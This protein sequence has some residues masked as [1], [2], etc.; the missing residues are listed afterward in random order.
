M[1]GQRLRKK[2]Q[3]NQTLLI[4]GAQNLLRV[5]G[6]EK[7]AALTPLVKVTYEHMV[8]RSYAILWL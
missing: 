7:S 6:H 4:P 3:K 1:I 5:A 8:V 2:V